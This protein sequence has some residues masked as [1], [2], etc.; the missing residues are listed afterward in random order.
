MRQR[1]QSKKIEKLNLIPIM[2]AVFIF[3][4]F[5]LMS[6][7]FVKIFDIGANLPMIKDVSEKPDKDKEPLDLTVELFDE[8]IIVKTGKTQA[9]K[10]QFTNSKED[11]EK[12]RNLM[13]ELKTE[14]PSENVVTIDSQEKVPFH[15]LVKTIDHTQ[16][17]KAGMKKLFEQVVFKK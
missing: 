2:D 13:V 15:R 9:V 8:K 11:W 10:S 5:L 17:D 16:K 1:Y 7:Q 14:N 6:S 3:I 12:F 4:F